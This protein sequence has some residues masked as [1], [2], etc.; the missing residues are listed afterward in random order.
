MMEYPTFVSCLA[1]MADSEDPVAQAIALETVGYIGVS[2]EGKV[3][4]LTLSHEMVFNNCPLQL[5]LAE[6]GNRMTDT[7]DRLELLITDSP[8]EARIR[9]MNAF[10]S[11]IKLD[12]ENQVV[13]FP[14]LL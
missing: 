9:A 6:L 14:P 12:K 11:L 7:I 10:A 1:A 13:F 8:T 4:Y 3:L 2:L 5:A